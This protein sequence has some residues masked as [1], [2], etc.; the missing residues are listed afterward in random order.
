[1]KSKLVEHGTS[2]MIEFEAETV[3]DAA[4]ITRFKLNGIKEIIGINASAFQD[5]TFFG[6]VYIGKRKQSSPEI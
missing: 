1:M 4:I 2:F 3:A 5:G 6:S